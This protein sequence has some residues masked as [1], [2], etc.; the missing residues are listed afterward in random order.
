MDEKIFSLL[1]H[2]QQMHLY[3]DVKKLS[4][5]CKENLLNQ[6]E[7][8][9]LNTYEIQ[10]EAKSSEIRENICPLTQCEFPNHKDKMAAEDYLANGKIGL[11]VSAGGEGSRLGGN[12]PKGMFPISVIK[13]KTLFQLLCEKIVAAQKKYNTQ[14]Y[15]AIMISPINKEAILTYFHKNKFFGL[16]EK[17]FLFFTQPMMPYMD[18]DSKW[19]MDDFGKIVCGPDGNGSIFAS[20]Y[21]SDLF[22]IFLSKGIEMVNVFS[23]DNPLIDPFDTELIGYHCKENKQVTIRAIKRDDNDTGLIVNNNGKIEIVEYIEL[24]PNEVIDNAFAY[25]GN[26]IVSISLIEDIA[27]KLEKFFSLHKVKKKKKFC[28]SNK[29]SEEELWKFER[30][31]FDFFPYVGEIGVL[32]F[33]KN[34][35]SPLKSFYGKNGVDAVKKA[36]LEKDRQVFF[37]LTGTYLIDKTFELSMDFHY[38]TDKLI[39]NCKNKNILKGEYITSE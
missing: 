34:T 39:C 3:E 20:F 30:W 18:D 17:Q 24:N 11:L 14:F 5:R 10:K 33:L 6:L 15:C 29:E 23:I 32:C 4:N 31:I 2:F 26:F 37:S 21:E 13:K 19:K 1:K 8:F 36:L 9:H 35:F 16:E 25:T 28:I 27:K 38:P 22:N 12:N 7:A